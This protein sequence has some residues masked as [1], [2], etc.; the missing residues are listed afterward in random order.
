MEN[1]PSEN[2]ANEAP[3]AVHQ[4]I[5]SGWQNYV[6]KRFPEAESDFRQALR[7]SDCLSDAYYGLGAS[8]RSQNRIPEAIEANPSRPSRSL[9]ERG[10]PRPPAGRPLAPLPRGRPDRPG[11]GKRHPGLPA[12][13]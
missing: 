2:P 11:A 5:A 6:F 10:D 7:L 3:P 4:W 13:L 1:Q 8:L 9:S 12:H